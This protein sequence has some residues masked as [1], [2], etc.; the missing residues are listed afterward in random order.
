MTQLRNLEN[1]GAS[2]VA[3][4]G[5]P[6]TPTKDLSKIV[7]VAPHILPVC[8]FL[9]AHISVQK[10]LLALVLI[11]RLIVSDVNVACHVE[12]EKC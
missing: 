3:I 8:L 9:Y 5:S 7:V 4:G 12:E 1:L 10:H 2:I 11:V 6:Q